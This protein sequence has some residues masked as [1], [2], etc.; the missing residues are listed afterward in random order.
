MPFPVGRWDLG[1]G[2]KA[3]GEE[4]S[5]LP[6]GLRTQGKM[7]QRESRVALCRMRF[8]L[9]R[10]QNSSAGEVWEDAFPDQYDGVFRWMTTLVLQGNGGGL[11]RKKFL[12][13]LLP[14]TSFE[15]KEIGRRI[16]SPEGGGFHRDNRIRG[17]KHTSLV[18]ED[19]GKRSRGS[20]HNS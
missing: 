1:E 11:A 18:E 12:H 2:V 9:T 6:E 14:V 10:T 20:L 15:G 5:T 3:S 8:P 13:S 17:L 7:L 19:G 4:L 16:F